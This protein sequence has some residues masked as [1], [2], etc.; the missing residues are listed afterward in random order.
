[1]T[2]GVQ[3]AYAAIAFD[4][5]SNNDTGSAGS[6]SLT[7]SHT[8]GAGGTDRILVVGVSIFHA[9]P[10]PTVQ[11]MTYAGSSMTLLAAKTN[12]A[13][14]NDRV[15]SELW[16]IKNPATGTNNNSITFTASVQAVAGGMSYTGVDQTTPFGTAA[17][18]GD[19]N[20]TI[21]VNVS[22]ATGEVVVDT[23][24]VRQSKIQ[25]NVLTKG[26][27]QTERYSDHSGTGT[28][29]NVEGAGSE[30]AGASTVTMSWTW[31]MFMMNSASERRTPRP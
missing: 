26:A 23:V 20:S 15:R 13:T 27:G 2:S 3:E 14:P 31:R 25:E 6:A 5:A 10:V 4:A 16:Y 11:S 28:T 19:D 17:T 8:V 1:M 12:V 18:F 30:E 7:V 22:S 21:S 9:T 24:A 29:A